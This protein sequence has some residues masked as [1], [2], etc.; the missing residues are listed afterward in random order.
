MDAARL[1]E[2]RAQAAMDE[3][4]A[5][6]R[7]AA[8]DADDERRLAETAASEKAEA[9]RIA[10]QE[11]LRR[12]HV[13]TEAAERLRELE[14]RAAEADAAAGEE[15]GRLAAAE[16]RAERAE[17]ALRVANEKVEEA[18]RA[19]AN[20]AIVARA[21]ASSSGSA[22]WIARPALPA[23]RGVGDSPPGPG[24]DSSLGG[25][26]GGFAG[27]LEAPGGWGRCRW[28][29]VPVGR[30]FP[31]R[32]PTA[33][34]RRVAEA[35]AAFSGRRRTST[36]RKDVEGAG[37][38]DASPGQ[39]RKA[40]AVEDIDDDSEPVMTSPSPPRLTPE[41]E[42]ELR[43]RRVRDA[44]AR[45]ARRVRAVRRAAAA[46]S[47]A[48]G[49]AGGTVTAA[50]T[51]W[52]PRWETPTTRHAIKFRDASAESVV[53]VRSSTAD[54]NRAAARFKNPGGAAKVTR[55]SS[56]RLVTTERGERRSRGRAGSRGVT[57]G[58]V[59]R[60]HVP[61]RNW[62]SPAPG[63]T[64]GDKSFGKSSGKSSGKRRRV[65]AAR[66]STLN[67]ASRVFERV[68]DRVY[69]E[70]GGGAATDDDGVRSG[71][72]PHGE[73][74]K[75]RLD[76]D[77]DDE[78]MFSVNLDAT[79]IAGV[80]YSSPTLTLTPKPSSLAAAAARLHRAHR[81]AAALGAFRSNVERSKRADEVEVTDRS[82]ASSRAIHASVRE[83]D[84][85]REGD[86]DGGGGGP[87][88]R[89]GTPRVGAGSLARR[90][91]GART[92]RERASKKAGVERAGQSRASETFRE[93]TGDVHAATPAPRSDPVRALP[94]VVRPRATQ[95]AAPPR[96]EVCD[97]TA[98]RVPI[99]PGLA[100]HPAHRVREKITASVASARGNA[101]EGKRREARDVARG[102]RS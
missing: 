56:P 59:A 30:R 6:V 43:E 70:M 16:A 10:E 53:A 72:L 79:P 78:S 3:L 7:K 15:A 36:S 101:P 63:T 18:A 67:V 8:E 47:G 46:A 34:A 102:H 66:A 55:A 87:A 33:A 82:R 100:R 31:P 95:G 20:G 60:A 9:E 26:G 92:L 69:R 51:G 75:D 81:L 2:E 64:T 28:V 86:A 93:A 90:H 91:R 42:A 32:Q 17:E 57:R 97:Q 45:A 21:M 40:R 50:V 13:M 4:N 99:A 37:D 71:D 29:R 52:R 38:D 14:A 54:M 41:E 84:R 88:E 89:G 48:A 27:F 39:K 58:R 62:A 61:V 35:R 44:R 76:D 11:E 24:G 96:A 74:G 83:G 68:F 23:P 77:D 25:G 65:D 5:A 12:L 98:T 22:G 19:A 1:A 73:K 85:V 80:E 49:D 94:T